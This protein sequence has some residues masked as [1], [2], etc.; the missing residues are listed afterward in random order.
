MLSAAADF[1]SYFR[2]VNEP[3][4]R[5]SLGSSA[6]SGAAPGCDGDSGE[7][8]AKKPK[9]DGWIF[10]I[11]FINFGLHNIFSNPKT[12]QTNPKLVIFS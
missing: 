2:G 1:W 11:F 8:T 12:S 5:I 7:P 3:R 6:T 9:T 10:Y 4:E